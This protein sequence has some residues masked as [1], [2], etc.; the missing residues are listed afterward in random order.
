IISVIKSKKTTKPSYRCPICKIKEFYERSSVRPRY[1][2]RNKH[3]FDT[4]QKEKIPITQYIASYEKK[5]LKP[6]DDI[7]VKEL[8]PYFINYNRYYSVQ[9]TQPAFISKKY[10]SILKALKGK[11]SSWSPEY[12]LKD[13]NNPPYQPSGIDHREFKTRKVPDRKGQSAFK[14][15]L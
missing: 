15:K 10:P 14:K 12:F 7:T 1:K 6:I 13:F 2:C 11:P 5:F 8:Q 3:E 4:P 9:P